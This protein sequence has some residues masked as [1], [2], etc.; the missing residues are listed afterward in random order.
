MANH[1]ANQKHIHFIGVGGIGMSALAVILVKR[2]Y[3]ISGS[4][5]KSSNTLKRLASHGITI[6]QQQNASNIKAICQ[7]D[8]LPTLVVV[9]TAVSKSN[10]ELQAAKEAKLK[11]CHRSDIL[12]ALIQRQPSIAVAG[13]HGKTTTSTFITTLLAKSNQDPTAVIGGVIPCYK[14]NG[15][16]GKGKMLVAEAD[17]SDG[18]LIKF[19]ANIGVITNL[20][21][22]HIDHYPD[23]N[24]LIKT[25][26]IFSK[27]CKRLLANYDCPTL[28]KNINAS[29]WW[30]TQTAQGVDFAGLPIEING[31]QTIADIYERGQHIGQ[32]DLPIP[33]LHNLSNAISAIASCRMA[34]IPFHILQKNIS[35]LKAPSRRFDFQGVWKGRQIVDDYAHHPSEVKATLKMARLMIDS[36][37]SP[38]PKTPKRLVVIFQPHRYSRTN[39]FLK[40][41]A[42]A[43]GH[44]DL[45]FIAPIYSAGEMP[46]KGANHQAL[47]TSIKKSFPNMPVFVAENLEELTNFVKTH[48]IPDDLVLTL[49]AGDINQLWENLRNH[50]TPN[51]WQASILAA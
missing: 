51:P 31:N 10:P 2:G 4:D 25:M 44:S 47:A 14:S 15:H 3:S 46:I 6:F 38:L 8:H 30:S 37:Q 20:E 22:D 43:L 19:Q 18:S 26:Q 9:S 5:Q 29:T 12:A 24:A 16:A 33:G 13:S 34:G 50:T 23:L 1:L 36:K 17:E 27:N 11:I 41:F 42:I 35:H 28:R 40:D 7:K 45:V 48:T 32:I 39:Q 21:L 49:G